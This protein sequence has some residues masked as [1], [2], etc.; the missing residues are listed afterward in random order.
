MIGSFYLIRIHRQVSGERKRFFV[1]IELTY[2]FNV[3]R[4]Q[5]LLNPLSLACQFISK[6]F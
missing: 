4:S 6:R 2:Q 3:S 1:I 5:L